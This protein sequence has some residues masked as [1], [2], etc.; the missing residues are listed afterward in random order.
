MSASN[1][2]I[3][4]ANALFGF[5]A[6]MLTV[7]FHRQRTNALLMQPKHQLNASLC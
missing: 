7:R 1:D 3:E 2:T 6:Q 4:S 5:G